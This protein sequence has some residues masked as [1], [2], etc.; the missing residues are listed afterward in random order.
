MLTEEKRSSEALIKRLDNVEEMMS[1]ASE[2]EKRFMK[3]DQLDAK[4][5]LE[6]VVAIT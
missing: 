5:I 2:I 1:K 4:S 6:Q 3:I